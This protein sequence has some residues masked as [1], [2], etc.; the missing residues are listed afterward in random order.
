MRAGLAS[1]L[2]KRRAKLLRVESPIEFLQRLRGESESLTLRVRQLAL[3][4][5]CQLPTALQGDA[6]LATD[7]DAELLD[8]P[9]SLVGSAYACGLRALGHEHPYLHLATI[10]IPVDLEALYL[11]SFDRL[12][13]ALQDWFLTAYQNN[14]RIVVSGCSED[15]LANL[16]PAGSDI[17]VFGSHKKRPQEI[18][19]DRRTFSKE[20][21]E[22][23]AIMQACVDRSID[24]IVCGTID[25]QTRLEI[26]CLMRRIP[27]HVPNT[28]S[29]IVSDTVQALVAYLEWCVY[30]KDSGLATLLDMMGITETAY[31]RFAKEYQLPSEL[32]AAALVASSKSELEGATYA[33][34]K[35]LAELIFDSRMSPSGISRLRFLAEWGEQI[36]ARFRPPTNGNASRKKR[37]G[38]RQHVARRSQR[39][40]IRCGRRRWWRARHYC[41][42]CHFSPPQLE[43][44]LDGHGFDRRWGN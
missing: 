10:R 41:K 30:E 35:Q 39:P 38:T 42:P 27:Y 25:H 36:S 6:Y 14:V 23:R 31:W 16:L 13:R 26:E 2:G 9:D 11:L 21:A 12:P 43:S 15:H 34:L 17:S 3:D 1:R 33:A 22:H 7:I 19:Y 37:H 18:N 24:T 28:T 32:S 5:I 29:V 44:C 20:K 40:A 4:T 8:D